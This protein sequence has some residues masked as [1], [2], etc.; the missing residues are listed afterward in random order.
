VHFTKFFFIEELLKERLEIS[1]QNAKL[2]ISLKSGKYY[3]VIKR[4]INGEHR[5]KKID[6]E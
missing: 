2:K 5:F 6:E 1:E 3:S 4:C